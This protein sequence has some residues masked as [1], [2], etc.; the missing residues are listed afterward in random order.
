VPAISAAII[1]TF[2]EAG[3]EITEDAVRLRPGSPDAT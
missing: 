2:A 3:V 1:R